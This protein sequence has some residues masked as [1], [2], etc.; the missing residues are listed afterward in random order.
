MVDHVQEWIADVLMCPT[1]S[2]PPDHTPLSEIEG[3]DSLR[4][5]SL[6]LGLERELNEKLSGEQIKC[7]VTVGDV[8][9]ILRRKVV[10]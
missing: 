9:G 5:V 3:W 7:I 8:A 6:I 10:G 1:E 2:L 4:H